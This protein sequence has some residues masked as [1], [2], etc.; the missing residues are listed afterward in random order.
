M[1]QFIY[2]LTLLIFCVVIFSCDS[3]TTK[4]NEFFYYPTRNVYYDVADKLY[5]YSLDGGKTWDSLSVK[6]DA[7]P[8]TLGTKRIVYSTTHDIWKDNAAHIQ[9]FSGHAINITTPDSLSN[10]DL[11]GERKIKKIKTN[12]EPVKKPEKKR[13]FFQRLFGKKDKN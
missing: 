6:N 9:Q 5:L 2:L 13:N 4:K 3:I 10:A 8:S 1:K 12:T 11:A 7:E